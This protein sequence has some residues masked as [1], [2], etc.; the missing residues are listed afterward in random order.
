[1]ANPAAQARANAQA[2][3][4][5]ATVAE[6]GRKFIRHQH[7]TD[8]NRFM[9]DTSIGAMH[10]GAQEDQE[11][12]TAW[13]ASAGAW[14]WEVTSN[15]FHCFIRDSVPVSYRYEDVATGHFV[16]LT[17][18]AVEWV[19]D[20]G[21]SED[22]VTFS[23]VTPTIDDDAIKWTDIAAGWD[24]RVQA[25]VQRLAKWLDIDS[26]ANLGSPTIGGTNE[27]LS[28]E[29]RFQKS[30]GLDIYIGGVL[31]NEQSNNPQ[32]TTSDIEFRDSA[33]GNPVFYFKAPLGNDFDGDSA[34]MV[35]HV[36]RQGANLLSRVKT[37]WSWLQ[38][39]TYPISLDDTVE[40]QTG[41]SNEDAMETEPGAV[42]LTAAA[43]LWS[44]TQHYATGQ[45]FVISSI[46]SGDTIDVCYM[47]IDVP[48]DF[49]DEVDDL[50]IGFEDT[51]DAGV[52]TTGTNNITNR[53]LTANPVTWN[54][55]TPDIGTGLQNTPSIVTPCQEVVD[56]GGWS[57]GN[58]MVV[59]VDRS[60]ATDNSD[61]AYDFW[62]VDSTNAP[63]LHIEYTA[64]STGLNVNISPSANYVQVV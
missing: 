28:F 11:I 13:V 56:R 25:Q 1:M 10:Y 16:E 21:D 53:S 40:D 14:D 63:K 45:Y 41:A 62:D 20:E 4:S 49:A 15:D 47:T 6:R 39:A 30:S 42:S 36:R 9:L 46:A 18:N 3:W 26:L 34:P 5:G 24:V 12:D 58:A 2:N 29:V 43:R 38:A 60:P 32:T 61:L 33:S 64:A 48:G 52:F 50:R 19:N 35:F 44:S 57:A 54:P 31:W 37:P 7:P 55:G 27:S 22:A 23:Q 17:V 59:V 8:P 51:D